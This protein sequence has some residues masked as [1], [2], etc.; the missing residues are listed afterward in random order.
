MLSDT[1]KNVQLMLHVKGINFPKAFEMIRQKNIP[2]LQLHSSML[3]GFGGFLFFH[4]QTSKLSFS[5]NNDRG[6]VGNRCQRHLCMR[7]TPI[8][9]ILLL[10]LLFQ[11]ASI[12]DRSCFL[13]H[14]DHYT[15]NWKPHEIFLPSSP[16]RNS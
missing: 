16:W 3:L 9:I 5:A 8:S 4:P 15:C 10:H 7:H 6:S 13:L 2:L 14:G 11:P 12:T 1:H